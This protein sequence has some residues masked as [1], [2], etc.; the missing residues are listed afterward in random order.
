VFTTSFIAL[1]VVGGARGD[2]DVIAGEISKLL[3]LKGMAYPFSAEYELALPKQPR[4]AGTTE[5]RRFF[6][7]NPHEL[8]SEETTESERLRVLVRDKK[9]LFGYS[10]ALGHALCEGAVELREKTPERW[11]EE[12]EFIHNSFASLDA[13][14]VEVVREFLS[15]AKVTQRDAAGAIR[16]Y[17]LS[18]S[19]LGELVIVLSSKTVQINAMAP[20]DAPA[21]PRTIVRYTYRLGP[22]PWA[23]A[24]VAE[25]VADF[26]KA[27]DK[28]IQKLTGQFTMFSAVRQA[29]PHAGEIRVISPAES[30]QLALRH[31]Y[32]LPTSRKAKVIEATDFD[33]QLHL[34][35][36]AGG[37][38]YSIGQYP[39]VSRIRDDESLTPFVTDR[40]KV[41]GY[42]VLNIRVLA[43]TNNIYYLKPGIALLVQDP[44]YKQMPFIDQNLDSLIESF[45]AVSDGKQRK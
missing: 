14:L 25:L 41:G 29:F 22:S 32:L 42:V 13:D 38:V 15:G 33:G 10:D 44:E 1:L 28:G 6:A 3:S 30:K 8:Y 26:R 11:L 23:A 2:T 20:P 45:S 35:I 19:R 37:K 24:A 43:G 34:R 5:R 31:G 7:A 9:I 4:V 18:G 27:G 12:H 17:H 36:Q 40:R 16:T 21:K 39:A